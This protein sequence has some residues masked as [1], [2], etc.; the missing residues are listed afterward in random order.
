MLAERLEKAWIARRAAVAIDKIMRFSH[1]GLVLGAGTLLT[2][3]GGLDRDLSID[4]SEPRL[5][6]LLAAAHG[7]RPTVSALAHLYKAVER[8]NE[9]QDA[10]AATHLALSGVDRLQRPEEDAHRLFLSDRM[11]SVGFDAGVIIKAVEAGG[12]ALTQLQKYDPDQPRVP[13]GSGRASGEW[14]SGV[15]SSAAPQ[16]LV[17]Q[18]EVNPDTITEVIAPPAGDIYACEEAENDCIKAANKAAQND[19]TNKVPRLLDT[20]NCVAAGAS[21][22]AMS[23]TVE[24][25]PFAAGKGEGGGIRFPDGGVVIIKKG[26]LDQYYPALFGRPPPIRRSAASA[27]PVDPD[28]VVEAGGFRRP[29]WSP[30]P[31]ETLASS[32]I[33][34]SGCRKILALLANR[35]D[36]QVI[37]RTCWLSGRWGKV[38]R[39]KI[40]FAPHGSSAT[41]LIACWSTPDLGYGMFMELENCCGSNGKDA[42]PSKP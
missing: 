20:V 26:Q 18:S 10:L 3:S 7:R 34:F 5:H 1:E 21:C 15:D 17:S 19:G 35:M 22:Q 23:W 28:E 33:G 13:A 24:D 2:K 40:A 4:P 9:G 31:G 37:E 32:V 16:S 12:R 30:G 14:T 25:L 41:A 39:A 38:I 11:L 6:V 8:W 36:G 42:P 29:P 27:T